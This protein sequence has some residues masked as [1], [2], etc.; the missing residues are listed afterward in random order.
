MFLRNAVRDPDRSKGRFPL[1][2][3]LVILVLLAG[4][5]VAVYSRHHRR[6]PPPREKIALGIVTTDNAVLVHIASEL[7][8]FSRYGI[9]LSITEYEVGSHVM[10]DLEAGILNIAAASEFALVREGFNRKDLLAV[11]SIARSNNIQ[12]IARKDRGIASPADLKGKTIGVLRG[13]TCEFFLSTFLAFGGI[14]NNEVQIVNIKPS[15]AASGILSRNIDAAMLWD[16]Y[17]YRLKTA[18]GKNAMV[19]DGQGGQDYY[20]LL[21]STRPF[22]DAHPAAVEKLLRALVDAERFTETNPAESKRIIQKHFRYDNAYMARTWAQNS[23]KVCLTQ[24]LLI[25]MED[26]GRWVKR[27]GW[28]YSQ[29]IPNYYALM[30]L[31]GLEKVNPDAVSII[32]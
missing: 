16:P 28:V 5:S 23:P 12:L 11:A 30:Y 19:W 4:A 32:H 25:H 29:G 10:D 15:D 20:V 27:R 21:I 6:L 22:T 7:G 1:A 17:A 2:L 3:C 14:L 18:L 13:T 9:D 24:D 31:D 8:F 26:E